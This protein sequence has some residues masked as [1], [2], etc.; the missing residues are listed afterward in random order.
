LQ[1]D[2]NFQ[3]CG[4]AS[5]PDN[6]YSY[7]QRVTSTTKT[8]KSLSEP[9]RYCNY[10]TVQEFISKVSGQQKDVEAMSDKV[11]QQQQEI[12]KMK[13]QMKTAKFDLAASRQTLSDITNKLAK[14]VKQR[15]CALKETDN[16]HEKLEAAYVHS[17][18]YE[19]E[20]LSKVEALSEAQTSKP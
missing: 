8:C 5:R 15:D 17:T 10:K 13:C 3:T 12:K 1:I 19:E 7:I 4:M 14:T 16:F 9:M 6:I 20:M 18:Y 2:V 11:D